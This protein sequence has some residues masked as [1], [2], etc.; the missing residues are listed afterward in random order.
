MKKIKNIILWVLSLFL[1]LMAIGLFTE[2][3]LS[4]F[5][6]LLAALF[7]NPFVLG[8]I[9]K[10]GKRLK[11]WISIPCVILLFLTAMATMPASNDIET[12]A[13][14]TEAEG[15]LTETEVAETEEITEQ[16]LAAAG[17]AVG[18]INTP[19][20]PEADKPDESELTVHFLDIG[21]GDATLIGCD[22]EYMLIDAGDNDKGT[23]VQN[24]L[25]K[26]GV[27]K[28]KYVIGTH[29]D[30]DHI[31]G[32]DVIL[33]KFP[34]ETVMMPDI[35]NNTATYRDVIDTMDTKGYLNTLPRVG[36]RYTLGGAE[37]TIL[38]PEKNYSDT[39][40][41][42]IVLRLTHG[43]NSFLFMGDAEEEA[44]TD[45]LNSD[46]TVDADV[47]KVG[48]HGSR[49]A[50]SKTFL[51]AVS[52]Q[53][54]VISC[55]E[56]NSYGHPHAET[57]NNLRAI[58]V[59]VFRTDEQGTI[60]AV[61][62]GKELEWN[63][64]PSETW[65]AGES[66]R[67]AESDSATET[68]DTKQQKAENKKEVTN[69]SAGDNA[70]MPENTGTQ[71]AVKPNS[72]SAAVQNEDQEKQVTA[73]ETEKAD[74]KEQVTGAGTGN[75]DNFETGEAPAGAN[76]IGNKRNGKLHRAS[77]HTLPKAENQVIFSTRE[78]AVNAGYDD[79][80]GNCNP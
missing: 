48:H 17:G 68:Q 30:A 41:S 73:A 76:Y 80:C 75:A 12:G 45:I 28:L 66:T 78:E 74:Q 70:V 69:S 27:T 55:A 59:Q 72:G 7:C 24:Y 63:C 9:A 4:G 61:S 32:L 39:N 11:K 15:A 51:Q 62:D 3:F 43:N 8:L 1:L 37:F 35:A 33:Y 46:V 5:L 77:C 42:S 14:S 22:G 26:Q 34:C 25:T 57:L 50:T 47:L 58:G 67:S 23:A 44:E 16:T 64:A 65:K 36:E 31:G 49:T 40:N 19:D 21:Q 18:E 54:A 56:N 10:S 79:P 38:G 60:V 13:D 52:P 53:Y 71:A 20:E 2:R 6:M 29:P